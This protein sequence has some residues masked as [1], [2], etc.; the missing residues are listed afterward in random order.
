[1]KTY[2]FKR[3]DISKGSLILVNKT[4]PINKSVNTNNLIGINQSRD[5]FLERKTA[6]GF[7]RL[8]TD[9]KCQ[10]EIIP[11]SGYRNYEEQKKIYDDSLAINGIEFTKQYVALP[12]CSEHQTG[13]A[14]DVAKNSDKIN[15]ICPNFPNSG[16]CGEFNKKASDYGFIQRYTKEKER[17]TGISCEPWHFR[18]VG[19]PHAH[20]INKNNFCLEEYLICIKEFEYQKEHLKININ[21]NEIEIFYID[22]NKNECIDLG[23]CLLLDISGNNEDGFIASVVRSSQ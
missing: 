8:I 18:Y 20:I 11:I 17:L 10:G 1:M 14:I 2:N 9:L 6:S 12:D 21:K 3:S 4:H 13:L 22:F 5:V 15:F 19:I 7:M 23:D 16:V